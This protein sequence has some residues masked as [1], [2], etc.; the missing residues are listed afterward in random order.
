MQRWT[1]R[2]V[3]TIGAVAISAAAVTPLLWACEDREQDNVDADADTGAGEEP[4]A[5]DAEIESDEETEAAADISEGSVDLVRYA[6]WTDVGN[7][8]PFQMSPTGPGGVVLLSL[9]FDTLTWKDEDGLIPWLAESWEATEDGTEFTF[10]IVEGATWHDSEPLTVEDV[11]FSYEYY[12]DHPFRWMAS[13]MVNAVS[14]DGDGAV[15]IELDRPYAAFLEDV[16][17]IVPIV[18][19][20]VWQDVDDPAQYDEPDATIGS[21]PFRITEYDRTDEAYRLTAFSDYWRGR[22]LFDE[23]QQLTMASETTMHAIQAGE[24]ELARSPDASVEDI[25]EEGSTL[26]IHETAPLSLVRLVINTE[27]PPLDR[28]E[29]RQAIAYALNRELISETITRAQP[30]VGSAGVVPPETPWFNPE[31]KQYPYDPDRARELLDGETID[32]TLVGSSDSAEIELMQ[33]MLEEV[34]INLDVQGVDAATRV[35]LLAEGSFQIALTAHIG[36]GGDPDYLRRW[37]AGEEANEFAQGSIFNHEEYTELGEQAAS[38]I[39]SEERREIVYRMQEIL[40]EELPTIVLY[41]RRFYW[42]YDSDAF[43]PIETWGGLMN[44]IPLPLNKLS[45]IER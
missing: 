30:I 28:T 7:M 3:V 10:Q 13:E 31:L 35:E 41:H 42:V 40:A 44:G 18:P 45:M 8:T 37:Y 34:G 1:R 32:L 4:D 15:V 5:A 23:F 12:Q 6:W 29:V 2:R 17:G 21:G 22:P 33:P 39:D 27:Q 36:V 38:T 19:R 9:I 11:A 43:T 20:H 14:V 16:A 24:L 26:A 25:L